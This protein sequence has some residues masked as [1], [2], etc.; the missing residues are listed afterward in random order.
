MLSSVLRSKQAVDVNI[1]IMRTFVRLRQML[2]SHADLT[3]KLEKLEKKYDE[4]FQ[5][6]FEAI[7]QLMTPPE[8]PKRKIGFHVKES[9][10]SYRK[11]KT[12]KKR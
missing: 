9:R 10:P 4:Q 2:T 11:H 7:R 6:V 1:A 8:K 12:K 3:R 5:V